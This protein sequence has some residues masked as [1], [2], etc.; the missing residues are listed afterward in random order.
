MNVASLL[1]AK[2]VGIK[3]LKD[4]LSALLKKHQPLVATDHGD[5]TYFL[6]PYEDMIEIVEILEEISDPTVVRSMQEGRRA[7]KKGGWI[8]VSNLWRKL[9]ISG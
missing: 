9:G 5:P 3:E 4:H 7:Y 6:V 2:H 8:P 1:R